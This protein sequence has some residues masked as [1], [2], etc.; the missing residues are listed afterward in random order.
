MQIVIFKINHAIFKKIFDMERFDTIN[1][2]KICLVVLC[3]YM[4]IL[5][6]KFWP[7]G[8]SSE[9]GLLSNL[10]WATP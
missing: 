6:L 7:L 9:L 1:I 2:Q 10:D 5:F 3:M 8:P 4:N